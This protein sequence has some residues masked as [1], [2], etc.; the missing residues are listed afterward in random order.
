M[1]EVERNLG[2]FKNQIDER[3]STAKECAATPRRT[4]QSI[5]KLVNSTASIQL[6]AEVGQGALLLGRS[7]PI[8]AR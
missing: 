3:S 4:C 7:A 2:S 1:I 8:D 5:D 6:A